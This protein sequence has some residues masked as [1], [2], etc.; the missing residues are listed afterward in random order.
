MVHLG[1]QVLHLV[2]NCFT[3]CSKGDCTGVVT[4]DLDQLDCWLEVKESK[5]LVEVEQVLASLGKS[6][7]LS[8]AGWES[9][10]FLQARPPQNR[11]ISIEEEAPSYGF[12][13]L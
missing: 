9:N 4:V 1:S 11:G 7:V 3:H 5:E 2:V 6:V 12:R 10:N 8:F 13:S